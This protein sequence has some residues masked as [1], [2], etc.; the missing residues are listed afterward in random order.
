MSKRKA[1]TCA[2]V[3][4]SQRISGTSVIPNLRKLARSDAD[5]IPLLL[6]GVEAAEAVDD[7]R[8]LDGE[9]EPVLRGERKC[10]AGI[11]NRGDGDAADGVGHEMRLSSE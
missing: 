11:Y 6:L 4:S 1:L 7:H 5:V 9:A 2:G 10:L 8:A 3:H